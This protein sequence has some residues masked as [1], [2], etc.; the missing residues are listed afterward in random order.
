VPKLVFIDVLD[1]RLE[2]DVREGIDV[3]DGKFWT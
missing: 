1:E 2:R 3:L